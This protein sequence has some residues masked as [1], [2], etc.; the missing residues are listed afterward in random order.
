MAFFY[1]AVV[2][3]QYLFN[4]YFIPDI[5]GYICMLRLISKCNILNNTLQHQISW[6]YKHPFICQYCKAKSIDMQFS[7]FG[8]GLNINIKI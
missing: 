4:Q 6:S 2:F 1:K 5:V 8:H 7:L 3:V